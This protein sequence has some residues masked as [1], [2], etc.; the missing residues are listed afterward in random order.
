MSSEFRPF[1]EGA[2][3][4]GIGDLTV[5]DAGD[6]VALYG[7]L[8]IEATRNGLADAEK[9]AAIADAVVKKLRSMELPESLPKAR[10]STR[11]NPFDQ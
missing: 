10:L 7:S 6:S 9:L 2:D 3:S 8:T 5:E 4:V 1:G 11:R